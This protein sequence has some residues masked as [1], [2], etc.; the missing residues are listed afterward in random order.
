MKVFIDS[1]CA[2]CHTGVALGGGMQKFPVAKPYKYANIGGFKGDKDGMVKVPTLRNI[3]QTAP[4]Y[5][6][7]AV[8]SLKEAVKIMGETRL[9]KELSDKE[10]QSIVSFLNALTSDKP[11][12]EYPILPDA[13]K[14]ILKP[15][16]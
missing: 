3:A 1:G 4:Y 7:G 12:V 6:N 8:W 16:P 2:S 10:V 9:G 14:N 13:N 15:R 11:K 5:H